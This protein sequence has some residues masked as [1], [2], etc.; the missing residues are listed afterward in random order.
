LAAA[1][2]NE[3]G[4]RL[5]QPRTVLFDKCAVGCRQKSSPN[6]PGLRRLLKDLVLHLFIDIADLLEV[7]DGQLLDGTYRTVP[8]QSE[9]KLE[10]SSFTEIGK[11]DRFS[12]IIELLPKFLFYP[13][14]FFL[15]FCMSSNYL[16]Y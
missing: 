14:A 10:T 4:K 8:A 7:R 16:N 6:V 1:S 3:L 12:W 13:I 2:T 11:R 9:S 5:V 15:D